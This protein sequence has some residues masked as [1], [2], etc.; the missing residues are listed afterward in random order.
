MALAAQGG[1]DPFLLLGGDPAEDGGAGDEPVQAAGVVEAVELGAGERL[2]AGQPGLRASA[3]TVRGSSPEITL[4][5]TPSRAEAAK[6][7]AT[8][9]RSSSA[10]AT[11]ATGSSAGSCGRPSA[12]R[13][14]APGRRRGQQQ[15]PQPPRRSRA[16]S[17]SARAAGRQ[18]RGTARPAAPSTQPP[19]SVTPPD[20]RSEERERH[21]VATVQAA[22]GRA[23]ATAGGGEVGVRRRCG[24]AR[25]ARLD[26]RRR[27]AVERL[28]SASVSRPVVS[29]PVLSVQ[30]TSTWLTD[31]TALT[32]CTSAPRPAIR[33]GADGVGD[34]DQEE[35]P[36]GHQPGQHRG[37]LHDP[38][39]R[40]PLERGL[41]QDRP[42]HQHD[43]R[44]DQP[45][46]ELD[47]PLQR[48]RVGG[49]GGP[50]R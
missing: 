12:S 33:G 27:P 45:D 16:A 17:A 41:G 7:S 8:S 42:A 23:A 50:R 19:S 6:V 37:G 48:G 38:Q 32:C 40:E 26:R 24:P 39:Q 29:V 46:D 1:D 10:N 5:A 13:S 28:D 47:A 36:V 31:S 20:Q 3:A 15:H 49:P 4:T 35:Q 43:Q 18:G 22:P 25:R 34:G 2:A 14:P 30:S 44:H 9:G 11:S 21:L